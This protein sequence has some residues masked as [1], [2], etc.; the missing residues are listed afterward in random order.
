M[1]TWQYLGYSG[2]LPFIILLWTST[3]TH[4]VALEKSEQ[5]FVFYSTVILSFLSGTLWRKD[6]LAPNAKAQI[7][8][9]I[10]C[11]YS[12]GCLL[13][14][15]FYSLILLPLGYVMLLLVE[16]LLCNNKEYAFSKHYF[17]MRLTLT[18][19]VSL[20]HAAALFLWF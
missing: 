18:F 14:P 19:L 11:L 20:L 6:T 10:I 3:N 12:F 7:T 1:K 8:S 2:L 5:A 15:I 9:N 13:L 4:V 17:T 16:Y